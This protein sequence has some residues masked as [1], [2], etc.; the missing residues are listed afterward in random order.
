MDANNHDQGHT[1]YVRTQST[2]WGQI[3]WMLTQHHPDPG[4]GKLGGGRN[5]ILER[6]IG[7]IRALGTH[8]CMLKMILLT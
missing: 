5:K 8:P 1:S 3:L 4:H 2:M 6:L 7:M